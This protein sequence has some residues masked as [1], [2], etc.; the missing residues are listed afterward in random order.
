MYTCPFVHFTFDPDLA[1]VGIHDTFA[2]MKAYTRPS[3][4]ACQGSVGL[5]EFAE[6]IGNVLFR[7]SDTAILYDQMGPPIFNV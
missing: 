6:K 5:V 1:P 3:V 2:D 7:Y 4:F